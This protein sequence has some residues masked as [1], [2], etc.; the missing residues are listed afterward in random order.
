MVKTVIDRENKY[1]QFTEGTYLYFTDM[2]PSVDF[3]KFKLS[4]PENSNFN[5]LW[6]YSF[7]P[8]QFLS[9]KP[10]E[11]YPNIIEYKSASGE[12]I[13]IYVSIFF[14]KDWV[15]ITTTDLDVKSHN[16]EIEHSII[17]ERDMF[18]GLKRLDYRIKSFSDIYQKQTSWNLYNNTEVVINNWKNQCRAIATLGGI[19]CLYFRTVPKESVDTLRT[20]NIR[21]V[22]DIKR[23]Y[24][25]LP[26]GEVPQDKF[27]YTDWD[28]PLQDD[29]MVHIV[30]ELFQQAF[31]ENTVPEEK[32]FIYFPLFQKIFRVSTM[33]PVNRYMGQV[34][35]WEVY[36]AKFED[37]ETVKIDKSL[38]QNVSDVDYVLGLGNVEISE[39]KFPE[40]E[41]DTEHEFLPE[42]T[43]EATHNKKVLDAQKSIIDD[44]QQH[45]N[46]S[47]V[48]SDKLDFKT[49]EE[50][51]TATAGMSNNLVDSTFNVSLKET[52]KIRESFDNRLNIV[53]VNPSSEAFPINM[54]DTKTVER[55]VI[56]LTWNL[57]DFT[58]KNKFSTTI[59]SGFN[60]SFDYVLSGSF[61][62]EI[63]ALS[64]RWGFQKFI[65]ELKRNKLSV[66]DVNSAQEF[67][68][69]F[70]LEKNEFY[71]IQLIYNV[72]RQSYTVLIYGLVLSEKQ[73]LHSQEFQ[74]KKSIFT[75]SVNT[76]VSKVYLFGGN[77]Y[78]GNL[79]LFIN[80]NKILHDTCKPLLVMNEFSK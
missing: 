11:E 40:T 45:I 3:S 4:I 63:L 74:I 31:G 8:N 22:S 29:F 43:P 39:D 64:D 69:D 58:T 30:I 35:W 59:G 15:D 56:A 55:R 78:L 52:E 54:Y 60:L 79:I 38:L 44:I 72:I 10:I 67:L 13:P 46:S 20:H 32:D 47:V 16:L 57:Y 25:N 28:M 6:A 2:F 80:D 62:S 9:Y 19:Q 66:N 71:Q 26:N 21:E 14:Q 42:V 12:N 7:V 24:I 17:L 75:N 65:I 1:L 23:M 18:Y 48:S 73:L 5:I 70:K 61:N 51:K 33:Q 34:A 27:I 41:W 49:I 50:R 37:D 68:V 36:L 53:S 76:E 77:Q